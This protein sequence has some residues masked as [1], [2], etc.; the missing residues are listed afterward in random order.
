M[1]AVDLGDVRLLHLLPGDCLLL[2]EQDVGE[3]VAMEGSRAESTYDETF[4]SG[5]PYTS[6]SPVKNRHISPLERKTRCSSDWCTLWM[7]FLCSSILDCL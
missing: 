2:A 3:E 1:A 7:S 4:A 5:G 6:P